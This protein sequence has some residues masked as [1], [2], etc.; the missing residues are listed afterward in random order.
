MQNQAETE[1]LDELLLTPGPV[2]LPPK[3]QAALSRQVVNHRSDSFRRLLASVSGRLAPLFERSGD[4]ATLPVG[5][6]E[7]ENRNGVTLLFPGSG[8]GALESAIVN[9]F[10]PGE[11]L[12]VVV[13]GEFGQRW[14]DIA[15][16]FGLEVGRY[17]VPWGE[18]FVE[19]ELAVWLDKTG[20]W[21]GLA[22]THNET[23]TGVLQDVSAAGRVA[24]A[25]GLRLLVD[26]VSS[27]GGAPL[28]AR[29]AGVTVAVS[30]SQKCLMTPPG[31]AVVWLAPDAEPLLEAARL[32]RAYWDYRAAMRAALRGETP[33]TPAVNLIYGLDAA[34]QLIEAEGLTEVWQRHRRL[35]AAWRERLTELG[36]RL[37][38]EQ[39]TASPTVTAAYPP[40]GV[41]AEE[42]RRHLA[43]RYHVT[44]AAGQGRLKGEIVRI[45]HMGSASDQDLERGM[46]AITAALGDLRHVPSTRSAL[47]RPSAVPEEGGN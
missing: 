15:A 11:R 28:A 39:A 16:S 9:L 17:E 40:P 45:A 18:A 30:A 20:P 29:S 41:D 7:E 5:G 10:S 27:L 8:T 3:V 14:A 26:A 21:D 22:V 12:A 35:A 2:P 47:Q 36:F 24:R 44:V 23:S 25:R 33:Y 6:D 37:L 34:L 1:F 32:P 46:A 38:S 43:A 42:L 31:L 19:G 13:A 4:S